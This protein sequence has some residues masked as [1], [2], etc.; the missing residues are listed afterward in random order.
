MVRSVARRLDVLELEGRW[1]ASALCFDCVS[2]GRVNNCETGTSYLREARID[3]TPKIAKPPML[4]MLL[5]ELN[6][7]AR[8]AATN[9]R[10]F[11]QGLTSAKTA[12]KQMLMLTIAEAPT[13]IQSKR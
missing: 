2:R 6:F 5:I 10:T 12:L 13:N 3:A 7:Q 8:T 4:P 9:M 1:S 11:V